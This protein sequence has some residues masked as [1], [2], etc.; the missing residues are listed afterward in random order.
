MGTPFPGS[1]KRAREFNKGAIVVGGVFVGLILWMVLSI[2]NTIKEPLTPLDQ[3]RL[4][5]PV[6]PKVLLPK[7][8]EDDKPINVPEIVANQIMH[9]KQLKLEYGGSASE[10]PNN[11]LLSGSRSTN[12]TP[13]KEVEDIYPYKMGVIR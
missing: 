9:G 5:P 10:R 3:S 13:K 11:Q 2:R 7:R 4:T 8:K 12:K 1:P 6:V